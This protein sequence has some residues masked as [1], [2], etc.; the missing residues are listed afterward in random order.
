MALY[1]DI[2]TNVVSELP[3]NIGE[4]SFFGRNLEPFTPESVEYEEDKVVVEDA[5]S[6]QRLKRTATPV[7]DEAAAT[8]ETPIEQE[9]I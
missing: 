5:V 9:V 8:I 1:R 3:E 6:T 4:H 7:A 2:N